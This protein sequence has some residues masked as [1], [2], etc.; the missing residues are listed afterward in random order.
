M[1]KNIDRLE[2]GKC[3]LDMC[4]I[5]SL[6]LKTGCKIK[7]AQSFDCADWNYYKPFQLGLRETVPATVPALRFFASSHFSQQGESG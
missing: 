6:V 7:S 4:I 2:T 1:A 5:P 3:N